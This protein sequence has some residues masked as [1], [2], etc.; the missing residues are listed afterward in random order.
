MLQNW[1]K[2]FKPNS[3][4]ALALTLSSRDLK[5]RHNR[6]IN[7]NNNAI[8]F[9]GF[10]TLS[11]HTQT[12]TEEREKHSQRQRQRKRI[13]LPNQFILMIQY[14]SF[15]IY[16]AVWMLSNSCS[17]ICIKSIHFLPT[18]ASIQPTIHP[19]SSRWICDVYGTFSSGE[20]SSFLLYGH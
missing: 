17:I 5:K 6:S 11:T 2:H 12:E 18:H 10:K 1:L 3:L 9:I 14:N 13:H 7:N 8:T 19:S 20:W 4:Q 15:D 16:Y